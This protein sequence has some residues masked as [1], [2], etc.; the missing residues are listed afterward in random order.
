MVDWKAPSSP[1]DFPNLFGA[2][3]IGFDCE[4]RDPNL[5]D[6][7]PGDIRRDGEIVG[8]SLAAD[9]GFKRYYPIAH[10]GGGNIDREVAIRYVRDVL[11]SAKR[12]T[13]AN[14]GYDCGWATTVGIRCLDFNFRTFDVQLLE[15]I[16][17]EDAGGYSLE[18]IA[19]RYLGRGKSEEVLRQ[20][21]EAAGVDPKG[22]LWKLPA[23]DVGEYAE[24]DAILPVEIVP[25]QLR[26]IREQ[27]LERVLDLEQRLFWVCLAMRE[28][29]V[30]VDLDKAA[31][32]NYELFMREQELMQKLVIEAGFEVN[33]WSS[34]D[35]ARYCFA[36]GVEFP[37]TE[38]GNPS[39]EAEFIATV[40][41]KFMQDVVLFR[42]I[43]KMRRDFIE[44]GVIEWNI[45]GRVHA[46]IHALREELYGTRSGRVSYSK[47][48]LQQ[49]PSRDPDW[50][51]IIR[52][53]YLPEE[54]ERWGRF[55]YSQQEPRLTVHYAALRGFPQADVVAGRYNEDPD[56]DYHQVVA[57]LAKIE[58]R[59]AKTINLGLTYGMGKKKLLRSLGV[60][61]DEAERIY[62][63]YHRL[64]PYV[65][66][67]TDEATRLADTRGY[68][69]TLS[70]RRRRFDKWN[71]VSWDLRKKHGY[72]AYRL[73]EAKTIWDGEPITRAFTHK[74]LNAVIQGGGADITKKAMVEI[75]ESYG[76]VPLIQVHDELDYSLTN[77]SH[78]SEIKR[79]ME[80]VYVLKVPLLVDCEV[81]SSWGE[82]NEY[83]AA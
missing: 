5:L 26:Q 45:N 1:E 74:A 66:L 56:T 18:A 10:A 4:T 34:D 15:P 65:R 30:R 38:K 60:P 51:P 7:G 79:A 25:L 40:D 76:Y 23:Q 35:L 9:S 81:G 73:E 17:D 64:L 62:A 13:G 57:E 44:G 54:G 58:R 80:N 53:L 37:L 61:I 19:Q 83:T 46:E 69:V 49:V 2:D 78:V 43:N 82:L 6:R 52:S 8:F 22:E 12:V 31:R 24:Q 48:N 20:R 33:P 50:G 16:I 32:L 28:K 21:A 68:V 77:L 29:G 55:D 72:R 42:K 75:Y 63:A 11:S 59:P 36:N 39:F 71:P 67:L 70:G 3:L 14:L 41:N 47:P 27:N